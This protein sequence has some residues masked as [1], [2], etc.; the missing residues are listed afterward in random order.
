[1][2]RNE[3]QNAADAGALAGAGNLYTPDGTSI[4]PNA[5]Q[6]GFEA[7]VANQSEQIPVEVNWSGG[8]SGDVERGH[9]SFATRTFTRNDSLATIPIWNYTE[10]ELDANPNFINAVRVRARRTNAVKP[11]ASYF[12]QIF[13]YTGFEKSAEAIAYIGFAG[14]MLPGELDFPIAICHESIYGEDGHLICNSGRA[15][16]SGVNVESGETGGWTSLYQG[17]QDGECVQV[18]DPCAGGTNANEVNNLVNMSTLCGGEGIPQG[19]VCGGGMTMATSGGEIQSAFNS[20]RNCF[21]NRANPTIPWQMKLP[22]V[23]CPGNNIT[24]CQETWGVVIVDVVHIT[25]GGED[26]QY[27]E[28]PT[29]M[30]YGGTN[31]L[32]T[33]GEMS[34]LDGRIGCWDRFVETF[35]LM[36]APG[37]EPPEAQYAKKTIYFL[38]GCTNGELTGVTGGVNY[39]VLAR[40]PVL[41]E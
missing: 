23:R 34:T 24:T 38:P 7:A 26:P 21:L 2:A 9:W 22:V 37:S 29:E 30:N 25:G 33:E 39:G 1:V 14:S 12:A 3:L 4:N 35:Q 15:I 36:N 6:F 28:I 5:N 41:V 11:I 10:D 18:D 19:T 8:N 32:C 17:T 16:N 13:G 27:N 20:L 40:I 31:Y